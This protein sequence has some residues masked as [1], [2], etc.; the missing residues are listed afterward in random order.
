MTISVDGVSTV[1]NICDLHAEEATI[2]SVKEAYSAKKKK[3]DDV[4][5]QAKALGLNVSEAGGLLVAVKEPKPP[6]PMVTDELDI[7]SPEVIPT[8]KLKGFVTTAGGEVGGQAIAGH[9]SFDVNSLRDQLPAEVL[10][11]HAE[12]TLVEGRSGQPLAIPKTRV[13]GTGTTRITIQ[14][15]DDATLQSRFKKM[16]TDSMNGNVPNFAQAGYQNTTK[17]CPICRGQS[18]VKQ[19]KKNITCPKCN[20]SGIISVY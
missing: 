2:K 17:T 19:N 20:G 9:S 16:A 13:D 5:A 10:Q 1:V 15:S 3:I 6:A 7:N 11:G 8:S 18:T 14:K 4:I 12:M